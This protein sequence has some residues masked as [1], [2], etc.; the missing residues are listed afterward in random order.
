[1]RDR[2]VAGPPFTAQERRDILDYCEDDVH[3]LARSGPVC[4]VTG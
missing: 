4:G 2:I 3:A 1:M